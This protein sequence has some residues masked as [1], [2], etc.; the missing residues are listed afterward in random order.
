MEA[1]IHLKNINKTYKLGEVDL[2]VLKDVSLDVKKGEKLCIMGSSGSGKSTL[3]HMIGILDRPSTGHVII[4]GKD[5]SRYSDDELAEIRSKK[6]GFVFQFFYLIPTLTA[7]E[8]VRLPMIFRGDGK[9]KQ[10]DK[11]AE[12]LKMVGLEQR[13]N[14]LPSQLSGGERQRVAIARAMANDPEIILADEPT[15][16][17]DSKSGQGIM[18][19]LLGLSKE[20]DVTLVI[21]THDKNMTRGM[22]RIVYLKDGQIIKEERKR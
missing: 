6:I 7:I 20:K 13:L 2:N 22:D 9:K 4:E 17:L 10:K 14:H 1:V 19:I 16:N 5:V 12:L 8:N 21:V 3:M 11:A 18:E 15:G